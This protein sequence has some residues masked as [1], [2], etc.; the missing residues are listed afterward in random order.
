MV[1]SRYPLATRPQDNRQ[2]TPTLSHTKSSAG[3]KRPRSPETT[4]DDTV[5][6]RCRPVALASAV[7]KLRDRRKEQKL[8]DKEAKEAVFREKYTRAFPLWTFYFDSDNIAPDVD[9]TSLEVR[10]EQLGGV[11]LLSFVK[12]VAMPD[13]PLFRLSKNSSQKK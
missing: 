12:P 9:L 10:I 1:P 8:Q 6:K 2:P 5:Q 3:N 7:P 13:M 11:S 4:V